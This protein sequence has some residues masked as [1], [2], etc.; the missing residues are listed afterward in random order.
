MSR[1]EVSK[2]TGEVW[3]KIDCE[4]KNRFVEEAKA[5][6]EKQKQQLK[7]EKEKTK[8]KEDKVEE[9]T[10][11]ESKPASKVVNPLAKFLMKAKTKEGDQKPAEAKKAAKPE[12]EST[13][14]KT[15]PSKYEEKVVPSNDEIEIIEI[16]PEKVAPRTSPR[17][18]CQTE[19][20]KESDVKETPKVPQATST[21][22]WLMQKVAQKITDLSL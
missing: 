10:S 20:K 22:L 21:P 11:K 2:K 17:K 16:A 8:V 7:E 18:K 9:K 15:K 1:S 6:K 14:E 3:N 5:E 4:T 19:E 13:E 12:N